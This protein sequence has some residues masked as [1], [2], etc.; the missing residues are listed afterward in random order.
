MSGRTV[1]VVVPATNSAGP[2]AAVSDPSPVIQPASGPNP[3][4]PPP[5]PGG[6]G[7]AAVSTVS[8]P[9]QLL[10]DRIQYTP[11]AIHSRD[12]PLVAKFHITSTKGGCVSGALVH[13]VGV[14]FDRL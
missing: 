4:P 5:P 13:A 7:C 11:S 12:E 8:L 6:G 14:P 9:N 2:G 10:I 3:P 1:R